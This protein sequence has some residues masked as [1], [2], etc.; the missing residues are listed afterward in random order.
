MPIPRPERSAAR[1]PPQL[2][3]VQ[4]PP[5]RA[6]LG[7]G[8]H[9]PEPIGTRAVF[10]SDWGNGPTVD[11][12][13]VEL[14]SYSAPL[15]PNPQPEWHSFFAVDTR[16]TPFAGDFDGDGKTDIITFTRTTLL[17]VGDV[18]VALSNGIAFGGEHRK[19]TTRDQ[20]PTRRSRSAT[21]TATERDDIA[22]WLGTTTRG[23]VRPASRHS[24]TGMNPRAG[25]AGTAS[26]AIRPT[27]SWPE[28]STATGARDLVAFERRAGQGLRGPV[29]RELVFRA[30]VRGCTASSRSA[31]G[32]GPGWPISTGTAG[33]TSRRSPRTP[34]TAF[35]DVYV[36]LSDGSRFRALIG[37]SDTRRSG[38]IGSPR[39]RDEE[40]RGGRPRRRPPGRT[41]SPSCR[42]P[43]GGH[44]YTVPLGGD[45]HGPERPLAG[46]GI[47][48]DAGDRDR[49]PR[50]RR[51]RRRARRTSSSS[52][53]ERGRV[54]V[55]LAAGA[56]PEGAR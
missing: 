4:Y 5:R 35:G 36:A 3:Q 54:Y 32:S 19:W 46:E 27:R 20:A 2:G 7:R 51:R 14:P 55:S 12:Y 6:L 52:R 25:M 43:C 10:A 39:P 37:T 28:T 53:R 26:A 45:R 16:E 23:G 31:R 47:R 56:T 9:D 24:G 40:V 49:V 21:T 11:T 13:V 30:P 1:A 33:P 38:T 41:S 48:Q 44:A 50:G 42:P 18:Y 34:P 29:D 8:P 15:P 17:A 22:T